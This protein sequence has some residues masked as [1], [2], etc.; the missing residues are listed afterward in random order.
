M[1]RLFV[2]IRPPRQIRELLCSVMGGIGGARWLADDQ[3][4][5]TLR[6]IGNVDTNQ[7]DDIVTALRHV[8]CE[9]FTLAV[10]G[11]G[12]FAKNGRIHTLWAGV[13]RSEPLE[14]LRRRADRTID[15]LLPAQP[16]RAYA[17]HITLARFGGSRALVDPLGLPAIPC[18]SFD[19]QAFQLFESV[20]S[21][22]GPSYSTI[23]RYE[24]G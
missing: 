16:K 23:E 12:T 19:V 5:L 7:V 17:P 14:R 2:A 15:G 21:K 3:L 20:L 9:Q 4:H 13:Q 11:A 24:L 1:H 10:Q 6:F 18:A 22:D 8:R